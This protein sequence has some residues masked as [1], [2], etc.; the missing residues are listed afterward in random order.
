[1]IDSL[2]H[3][4]LFLLYRVT[5]W[6][7][8]CEIIH[9][10]KKFSTKITLKFLFTPPETYV[11]NYIRI[12]N[13][14]QNRNLSKSLFSWYLIFLEGLKSDIEFMLVNIWVIIFS[15]NI[16]LVWIAWLA[17]KITLLTYIYNNEVKWK[18]T[19]SQ[20]IATEVI[21]CNLTI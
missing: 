14:Q 4:S 5:S 11:S 7:Y 1:M 9:F 18:K 13:W 6:Q 10:Q 3:T 16:P 2:L 19:F 15:I 17:K 8:F 21:T 20:L 12:F